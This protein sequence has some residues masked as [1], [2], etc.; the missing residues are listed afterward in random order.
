MEKIIGDW[1]TEVKLSTEEAKDICRVGQGEECCAFLVMAPGGFECIRM[2]Y[3]MNSNI[4]S[5][6]EE[7]TMN[8][9]GEGGWEK[10]AWEDDLKAFE[11]SSG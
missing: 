9:K 2:S 3:P 4:F 1:S 8:A 7:G 11:K 6:L 10:C 5:R